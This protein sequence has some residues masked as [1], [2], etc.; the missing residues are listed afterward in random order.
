MLPEF[1][2]DKE[3]NMYNTK[4]HYSFSLKLTLQCI[5]ITVVLYLSPG[6]MMSKERLW[7]LGWGREKRTRSRTAQG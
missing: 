3:V 4:A 5:Q 6:T 2:L 1:Y 7:S